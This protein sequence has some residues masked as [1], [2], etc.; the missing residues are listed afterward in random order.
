MHPHHINIKDF[1]VTTIKSKPK[2]T[3]PQGYDDSLIFIE[4]QVLL[5]AQRLNKVVGLMFSL[6]KKP[7]GCY[8]AIYVVY[9]MILTR[10][11]YLGFI[12]SLSK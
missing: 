10:M 6:Q 12:S 9:L 11:Q 1:R 3:V 5:L 2:I 4:N 7:K 8:S